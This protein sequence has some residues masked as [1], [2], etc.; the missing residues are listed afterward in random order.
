MAND[1]PH[2]ATS[3]FYV[4]TRAMPSW[5]GK[6]RGWKKFKEE[7]TWHLHGV[8]LSDR[9][10]V[11]ARLKPWLEGEAKERF[12]EIAKLLLH[13]QLLAMQRFLR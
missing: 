10:Y 1:G 11:V 12:N 9:R 6:P 5:D 4:T 7:F 2:T 3:Q 13:M 8:K